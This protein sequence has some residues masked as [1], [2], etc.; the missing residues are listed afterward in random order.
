MELSTLLKQRLENGKI[1]TLE[2]TNSSDLK[3]EKER[4]E[5]MSMIQDREQRKTF[6]D[7]I[8]TVT[9]IYIAVVLFILIACGF[10]RLQFSDTVLITLLST[11]TA[12]ILSLLVIVFN[13]IFP[14]K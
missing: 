4:Q 12:N 2:D 6:A 11:T 5:L 7:K 9:V 14:K 10:S 8:F 3:R 13:H 1:S